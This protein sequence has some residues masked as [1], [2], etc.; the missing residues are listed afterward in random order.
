MKGFYGWRM[1]IAGSALQFL[2]GGLM[3]QAFG[4]YV[5]VL[6]TERGWSK[7]AL[8]GAAALQSVESA[9]IGPALGWLVDRVGEHRLIQLGIVI[10][11]LGLIA[12]GSVDTLAGFY[13]AVL[14]VALGSSLAGYF[15]INIALI[16]WFERQRAR[17]LSSA[18]LGLALGGLFVPVVAASI[19]AF[20]WRATAIGSG[21]LAIAIGWPLARVFRGRPDALGMRIDGASAQTAAA[22]D[23]PAPTHTDVTPGLTARQALRTGAFWLL[24][25]G[26]GI[27]LFAVTSVNVHAITHIKE[28]L[29]YSVAQASLVITLMTGAQIGGVLLGMAVGD[30]YDK[31][32][33]CAACMLGHGFGLLM[34]TYASGSAM[35]AAFA[36]LHGMAWGLRGP[37]MQAI[38]ADYFG[39]RSIGMIMG[40]S[41]VVIAV[42]QV[43]GPLVAGAFAD[44]TGDYRLGYTLLA[45]L[46][47]GGSFA[48]LLARPPVLPGPT[49]AE[50][51]AA[52]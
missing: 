11:G 35:L 2:Q 19:T 6:T 39:R 46:A 14:L 45:V 36:L 42:G 52:R 17:A 8:S 28:G 26:H 40:L 20:G 21:V 18:G 25:A 23:A 51:P 48:F 29:G 30:R 50:M 33:I 9:L 41:S 27:A 1:V 7:T 49:S 31:R 47:L 4:A 24:S 22:T 16:H 32:W 38:R 37:L 12:M 5:A 15:T 34:L 3:M 44:L 43:G 13:G 10:F